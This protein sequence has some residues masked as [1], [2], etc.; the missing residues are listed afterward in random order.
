MPRHLR[1]LAR[2]VDLSRARANH[3]PEVR[4][5]VLQIEHISECVDRRGNT[6]ATR[7]GDLTQTEVLH[8]RRALATQRAQHVPATPLEDT[9][10]AFARVL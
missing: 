2:D 4:E 5:P 1:H 10:G 7:K 8:P 9:P 3:C 6:G